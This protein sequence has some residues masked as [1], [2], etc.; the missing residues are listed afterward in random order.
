MNNPGYPD[1]PP[2]PGG[3]FPD[4]PSHFLAR[5]D[6]FRGEH[7]APAQWTP[8]NFDLTLHPDSFVLGEKDTSHRLVLC[9]SFDE[10]KYYMIFVQMSV[11]GHLSQF[12]R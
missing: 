12:G 3:P 5:P 1:I 6:A 9:M 10:T 7:P 8:P 4:K 2:I 11:I